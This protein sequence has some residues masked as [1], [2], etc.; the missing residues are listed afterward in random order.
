VLFIGGAGVLQPIS[1]AF[2]TAMADVPAAEAYATLH[3]TFGVMLMAAVIIYM[4]S[5]ET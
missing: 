1:G 2:M 3:I 4:F 5:R